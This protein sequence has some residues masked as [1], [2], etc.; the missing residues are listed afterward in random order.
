M[1]LIS[2]LPLNSEIE[3]ASLTSNSEAPE[4]NI[5]SQFGCS[6]VQTHASIITHAASL[7]RTPLEG[8]NAIHRNI[9]V[10]NLYVHVT[11]SKECVSAFNCF[12]TD[13]KKYIYLLMNTVM[14]LQIGCGKG[15]P[16]C[17][18]CRMLAIYLITFFAIIAGMNFIFFAHACVI[19]D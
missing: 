7:S 8:P 4:T 10:G 2:H 15:W 6:N 1:N 14:N 18:L 12:C 16:N 11:N 9:F 17:P 19:D 5:D 3:G 13:H